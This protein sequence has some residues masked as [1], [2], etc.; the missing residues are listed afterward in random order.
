MSLRYIIKD[1]TTVTRGI[2]AHGVNCAGKM[3]SG[4]AKAIRNK[5]PE[6]YRR[7]MD[8]PT[9]Q[10][11]RG[12]CILGEVDFICIGDED[13]VVANCYTQKTYGYDNKKYAD[14][15]GVIIALQ[16]ICQMLDLRI[17]GA[18]D[19]PNVTAVYIPRIGCGLGGLDWDTEVGLFVEELARKYPQIDIYVCDLPEKT[20]EPDVT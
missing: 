1:V 14:L 13:I 16:H 7:F 11:P 3:N 9:A 15:V 5:W 4:V 6:V 18:L 19:N 20:N 8:H 2:V 17:I 10:T 12:R